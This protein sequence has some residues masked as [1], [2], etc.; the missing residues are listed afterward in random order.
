ML[1]RNNTR[2]IFQNPDDM[3]LLINRG[4]LAL[5]QGVLIRGSGVN[6]TQFNVTS[7]VDGVPLVVLASRMLWD[8]GVGSSLRQ[9][10]Y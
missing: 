6:T 10:A 9:H 8:K 1:N 5:G 3:D 4:V 7:E 2:V